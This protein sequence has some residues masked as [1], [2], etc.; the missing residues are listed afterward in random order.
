VGGLVQRKPR[1]D[2][3]L[4]SRALGLPARRAGNVYALP[5]HREACAVFYPQESPAT[6]SCF[7][8]REVTLS[9]AYTPRI[10]ARSLARRNARVRQAKINCPEYA[11]GENLPAKF[12]GANRD[13]SMMEKE[14]K[15]KIRICSCDEASLR[16]VQDS[17]GRLDYFFLAGR[18]PS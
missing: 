17:K 9:S 4:A 7:R 10:S 16:S 12:E 13:A 8:G 15:G 6:R 14:R 1:A 18:S 2:R 5:C 3:P 11:R